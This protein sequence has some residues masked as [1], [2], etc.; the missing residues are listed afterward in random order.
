MRYGKFCLQRMLIV[1]FKQ[2]ERCAY[3]GESFDD[4]TEYCYWNRARVCSQC[5]Y[6]LEHG[7]EIELPI[8][9]AL[10]SV[11]LIWSLFFVVAILVWVF[12]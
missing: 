8:A 12:D 1:E 9:N 6:A 11:A 7:D 3:C 5:M 4:P 2:V 10:V